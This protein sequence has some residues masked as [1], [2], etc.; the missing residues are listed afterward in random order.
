MTDLQDYGFYSAELDRLEARVAVIEA[1]RVQSW[2]RLVDFPALKVR[3]PIS[4][5]R[6]VIVSLVG[7]CARSHEARSQY[8]I[9]A[10]RHGKMMLI[11]RCRDCDSAGRLRANQKREQNKVRKYRMMLME[12]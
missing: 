9:E 8:T 11:S 12:N 10:A 3:V 7:G 6:S 1:E 5:Q 4:N 2:Q